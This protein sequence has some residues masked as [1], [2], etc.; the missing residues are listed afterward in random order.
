M[1][2]LQYLLNIQSKAYGKQGSVCVAVPGL[3]RVRPRFTLQDMHCDVVPEPGGGV[4]PPRV[5]EVAGEHAGVRGAGRLQQQLQPH[6]LNI[7]PYNIKPS[8]K[9]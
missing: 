5:V 4:G 7:P 9:S 8:S 1:L 3:L 6:Q 2:C